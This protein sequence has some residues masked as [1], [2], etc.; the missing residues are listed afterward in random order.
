MLRLQ[1]AGGK[2]LKK[3]RNLTLEPVYCVNTQHFLELPNNLS[4]SQEFGFKKLTQRYPVQVCCLLL[5]ENRVDKILK[6]LTPL[7]E[8]ILT[9]LM[10]IKQV[11]TAVIEMK[12][13]S[14]LLPGGSD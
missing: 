5:E 13:A 10:G 2:A 7:V 14:H 1:F 11:K 3:N 8:T 9:E 4:I 6:P 12:I